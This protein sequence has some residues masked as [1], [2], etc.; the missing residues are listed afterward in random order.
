MTMFHVYIILRPT[1][2]DET[3]YFFS[4]WQSGIIFII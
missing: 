3:R 2:L 1:G 4:S